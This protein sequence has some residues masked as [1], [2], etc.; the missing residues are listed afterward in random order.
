MTQTIRES[1]ENSFLEMACLFQEEFYL[2]LSIC[3][4]KSKMAPVLDVFGINIIG[5]SKM[6][7]IKY[8]VCFCQIQLYK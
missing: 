6:I 8:L 5:A 3:L 2:D 4:F 1:R 7:M